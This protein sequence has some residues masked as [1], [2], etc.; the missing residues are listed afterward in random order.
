VTWRPA[1][2]SAW[3]SGAWRRYEEANATVIL[4]P[5]EREGTRW[6][7]ARW[8]PTPALASTGRT[9]W[10][11]ASARSSAPA[12]RRDWQATPRLACRWTARR[13]SRSS[14]SASA[15]ASCTAAAPPP[16]SRCARPALIGGATVYRQTFENRPGME[17]WNQLR[18]WTTL[19]AG[20]G[21]DPGA[22]RGGVRDDP[23]HDDAGTLAAARLSRCG[24]AGGTSAASCCGGPD[25]AVPARAARALFPLCAGC[26]EGVETGDRSAYYPPPQL[27]VNC[28]DGTSSSRAWSGRA[29]GT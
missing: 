21:R 6:R 8:R 29:R 20:F 25:G 19:R 14:S 5:L 11:A 12:T 22:R 4:R 15:R 10:S 7:R 28:H 18:A 13:S 17:D 23:A 16:T 3:A 1:G 2:L 26:H 24:A 27:C 9:A